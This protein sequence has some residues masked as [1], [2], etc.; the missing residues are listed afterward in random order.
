M[1]FCHASPM[2]HPVV[3]LAGGEDFLAERE[4]RRIVGLL[5]QISP[6]ILRHDIDASDEGAAAAFLDACSPG[7]FDEEAVVIVDR[8]EE[9]SETLQNALLQLIE[10]S[11]NT[12]KV[13]LIQ[14]GLV[15]G[16]SFI[17][18][19][20]KS[21]AEK[22]TFEKIKGRAFDDFIV[23]EF[24]HYK[25]KV[26][27]DV[28]RVLRQ[29]IGDDV[30]ALAGGISQLCSDLGDKEIVAADVEK[31]Y[32][33]MA[34][35]STFAIADNVYDGKSVAALTA[36]RWAI[37]RDPNVG[38]A[39]VATSASTLRSLVAVATAPGGVSEAEIARLAGTPP[40]KVRSLKDQVRRWNPSDLADAALLLTQLDAALKG[41]EIDEYGEV[42]VLDPVQRQALLERTLIEISRR[43]LRARS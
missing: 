35:V 39:V 15:K 19:L 14:R 12:T 29:S 32:E 33:G 6:E 25:R 27:P 24:R 43:P 21:S 26:Q 11:D 20:K 18:K 8:V 5:K 36:L 42:T 40:W 37:E 10:D 1:T 38:P 9:A 41:G 7:L 28:V 3:L 13:L 31:Y 34:G 2:A 4:V 16:K 22:L 30:R 23:N 17:E